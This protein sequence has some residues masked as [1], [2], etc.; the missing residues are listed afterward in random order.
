ML[1]KHRK[2]KRNTCESA[3]ADDDEC[4]KHQTRETRQFVVQT[5]SLPSLQIAEYA[6][7]IPPAKLRK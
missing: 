3:Y 2:L 6:A 7:G 5:C 1:F 4:L